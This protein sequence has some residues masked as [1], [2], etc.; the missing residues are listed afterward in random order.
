MKAKTHLPTV[1]IFIPQFHRP[2]HWRF[3]EEINEEDF[4]LT[5]INGVKH[6]QS[7]VYLL[8]LNWI[9]ILKITSTY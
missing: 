4:L 1:I 7:N 6:H 8:E 3:T 5:C 2:G 9:S